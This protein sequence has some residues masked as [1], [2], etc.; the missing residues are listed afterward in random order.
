MIRPWTSRDSAKVKIAEITRTRNRIWHLREEKNESE[1]CLVTGK[2][3]K[4]SLQ[5]IEI[6]QMFSSSNRGLGLRS[7]ACTA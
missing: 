2:V 3:W 6:V 7:E 5:M 4:Y 1:F